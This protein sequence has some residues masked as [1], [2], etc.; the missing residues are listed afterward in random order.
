LFAFQER[1]YRPPNLF[2][3]CVRS[4]VHV[5]SKRDIAAPSQ[6]CASIWPF[7][8]PLRDATIGNVLT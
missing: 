5:G 3:M 2:G 8:M 6:Y 7:P 1:H 4:A